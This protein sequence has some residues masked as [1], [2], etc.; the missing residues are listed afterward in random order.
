MSKP[1]QYTSAEIKA[2]IEELDK[3]GADLQE[4]I[5]KY[6]NNSLGNKILVSFYNQNLRKVQELQLKLRE[7]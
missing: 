2:N 5:K 4:L 7:G 6:K 1:K 3:V